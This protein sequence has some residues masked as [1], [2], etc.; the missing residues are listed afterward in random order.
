MSMKAVRDYTARNGCEA[1]ACFSSYSVMDSAFLSLCV[2]ERERDV[3]RHNTKELKETPTNRLT[4]APSLPRFITIEIRILDER[5]ISSFISS[6]SSS[7]S[8][9][10]IRGVKN[11]NFEDEKYCFISKAAFSSTF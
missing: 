8:L 10:C 6:T 9:F 7:S 11:A 5:K 4:R 2:W 3:C 1:H